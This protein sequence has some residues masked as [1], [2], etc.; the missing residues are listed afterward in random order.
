[1]AEL[2]VNASP[3]RHSFTM[4]KNQKSH[5]LRSGEY[6]GAWHSAEMFCLEFYRDLSSIMTHGIVHVNAENAKAFAVGRTPF[7]FVQHWKFPIEKIFLI[8]FR[9]P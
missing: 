4:P 6:I 5:G 3:L 1:M 8:E 9:L 7:L 2:D